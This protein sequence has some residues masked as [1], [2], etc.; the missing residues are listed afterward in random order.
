[1][2]GKLASLPNYNGLNVPHDYFD[3]AMKKLRTRFLK[4][5]V[6]GAVRPAPSAEQRKVDAKVAEIA[7]QP[8]PTIRELSAEGYANRGLE[9]L[10]SS[11]YDGAMIDL[12]EAIRLKPDYALAYSRRGVVKQRKGDSDGAITDINKAIELNPEL[13]HTYINR[14]L[15]RSAEKDYDGAIA[16]Y[17]EAIRLNPAFAL[18]YNNRGN[19]CYDKGDLNG[20]ISD[21]NEAIRLNPDY[22]NANGGL[23]NCYYTLKHYAESLNA[24]ER[25]LALAGSNPSQFVLDRV[26]ELKKK[27]GR[28]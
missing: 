11:D 10:N 8:I 20:A 17:N 26:A 27:L 9:R 6:Y 15:I 13:P 1:L 18:A 21:Y 3:E 2:I 24:Y 12:D 23:G 7:A 5:P 28:T 19:E 16:D 25:Y 14:G 4:Q 22:A